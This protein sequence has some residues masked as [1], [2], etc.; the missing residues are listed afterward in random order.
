MKISIV[1][2]IFNAERYLA[3]TLDG[4]LA[5]TVADWDLV[6]VDDGSQDG[7]AEI[8]GRYAA[9]DSRIRLMTQ[10]NRGVAE[11]RNRGLAHTRP[12][13]D[14]VA[15][16]DADDV[17][18]MDALA[19]LAAALVEDPQAVAAHGLARKVHADGI[20]TASDVAQRQGYRRRK[21]VARFS[22]GCR[23]AGCTRT[24]PTTFA[25]LIYDC[26]LWTPGVALIRRA[27]LSEVSPLFDQGVAPAEDWDLWLRLSLR[28]HFAFVDRILLS[29]RQHTAGA[30]Q[31]EGRLVQAMS[32]VRRKMLALPELTPTQRRLARWRLHRLYASVERHNAVGLWGEGARQLERGRVPA[33]LA[34]MGRAG[35]CYARYLVLCLLWRDAGVQGPLPP[36]LNGGLALRP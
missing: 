13:A 22:G 23:A 29:Y 30:S 4:V 1:I 3:Q 2:P 20:P 14:A 8:A 27:A 21:I 32:H 5:Q 35:R 25:M 7:S 34:A 9:R 33:G 18:E 6:L 17:W 26:W 12:D 15:F 10:P 36:R 31:Q 19:V 24:E 11:A 16:L 28:G